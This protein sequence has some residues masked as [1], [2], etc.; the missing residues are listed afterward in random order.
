L[1]EENKRFLI[2]RKPFL[3]T[4]IGSGEQNF[5]YKG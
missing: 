2:S 4:L 1:T 5:R 3:I